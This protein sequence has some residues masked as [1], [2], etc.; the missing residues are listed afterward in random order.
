MSATTSLYMRLKSFADGAIDLLS[1]LFLPIIALLVSTGILKGIFILLTVNHLVPEGSSTYVILNAM[2]DAFFY[3]IPVFLA[4]TAAKRFNTDP[5]TAMLLACVLVY[6]DVTQL[7]KAP[8]AGGMESVE[9]L[10]QSLAATMGQ[11]GDGSAVA[12]MFGHVGG[13]GG[14]Q[15]PDLFGWPMGQVMYPS[16]VIPILLAVYCLQ[17]V[18][19]LGKKIFPE[20]VRGLFTPPLCIIV[21]TPF[22]L[23][24]LGPIGTWLGALLGGGYELVYGLS[25]LIA[26]LIVGTVQ[27]FIGMLGLQWGFFPIAINNV[28]V[29]GFDTLMPLFG[30]AMFAQAGAALAVAVRSK[31]KVFKTEA[32]SAGLIALLGVT[33]PAVF[34]VTLRLKRPMVCACVAGGLGGALAGFFKVSAPSFAIPAVTTL[35]VFM[36]PS[37]M[38]YLTALGIAFG[39]SFVL[40]LIVGFKD[41]KYSE[42]TMIEE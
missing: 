29:Y 22:T 16:S 26:G 31:N 9:A 19:K 13:A 41:I 2:S 25:P 5:F 18:E 40:T 28:A 34:G 23:V 30:T 33:E 37:F 12:T 10:V 15:G 27:P 32:F 42:V 4:Y 36:G 6:P 1:A 21:M 38:W 8:G 7:M 11:S 24:I 17:Y 39:L 35:P 14:W 3:F 20:A